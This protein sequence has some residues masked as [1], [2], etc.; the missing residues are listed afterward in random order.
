MKR[1]G[2]YS[3]MHTRCCVTSKETRA[4]GMRPS[5]KGVWNSG[6]YQRHMEQMQIWPSR[7]KVLAQ[8]F[9]TYKVCN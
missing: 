9:G 8:V 4:K 5:D 2:K 7:E 1:V 3:S 6:Q